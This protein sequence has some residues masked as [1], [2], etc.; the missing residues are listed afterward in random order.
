MAVYMGMFGFVAK[1]E[2]LETSCYNSECIVRIVKIYSMPEETEKFKNI[3]IKDV[4]EGD[5]VVVEEGWLFNTKK[6]AVDYAEKSKSFETTG[7]SLLGLP[8]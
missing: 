5:E 2:I 1:V 4:K 8:F 3:N 6:L 7:H